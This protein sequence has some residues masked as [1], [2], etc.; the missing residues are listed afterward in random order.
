MSSAAPERPAFSILFV[1]TGNICR[2]PSAELLARH[3]V[4][5]ALPAE[6]AERVR[7]ASAG[8]LGWTDSPI[9]PLAAVALK[10]YGVDPSGFRGAELT[11]SLVREADLILGAEREHRAMAV[12]MAPAAAARS[13]TLR[14]F[15]RLCTAVR[16]ETLP[17]GDVAVRGRALVAAAAAQRGLI[18]AVAPEDDDIPDP[19]GAKQPAFTTCLS[20]IAE[21]LRRPLALLTGT[22]EATT[23]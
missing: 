2:S 22:E 7:V 20:D 16:P 1:C 18:A 8:T 13:F 4:D 23:S 21:C 9:E 6:Q 11:A 15:A 5:G 3:V 10:S 19:F 14:Q 17:T 12:T